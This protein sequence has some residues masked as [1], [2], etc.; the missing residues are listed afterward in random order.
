MWLVGLSSGLQAQQP[1]PFPP[2]SHLSH[3]EVLLFT[4][5]GCIE[6]TLSSHLPYASLRTWIFLNHGAVQWG[7]DTD[8][9]PGTA[10]Q[11]HR[12]RG[13]GAFGMGSG[14]WLRMVP[15]TLPCPLA[16]SRLNKDGASA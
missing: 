8:V 7:G 15:E 2:L 4:V 14:F 12:S 16:F 5:G 9:V 3:S 11:S 10:R 13:F 1:G 6:L